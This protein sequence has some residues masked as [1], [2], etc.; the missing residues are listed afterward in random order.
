MPKLL[1]TELGSNL[2]FSL[3]LLRVTSIL[4]ALKQYFLHLWLQIEVVTSVL[5]TFLSDRGMLNGGFS[6]VQI[7]NR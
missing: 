2:C 1:L 4:T 3:R 7:L 5:A 6:R